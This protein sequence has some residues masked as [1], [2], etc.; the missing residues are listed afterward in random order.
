MPRAIMRWN[1]RA[2]YP[3]HTLL[4]VP[5]SWR[6]TLAPFLF[7]CFEDSYSVSMPL[8]ERHAGLGSIY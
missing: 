5:K 7:G 2:T 1:N 3:I 8:S 6:F 4:M